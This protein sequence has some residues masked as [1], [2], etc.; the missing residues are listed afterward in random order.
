MYPKWR[1]DLGEKKQELA[2][3]GYSLFVTLDEKVPRS[4][5]LRKRPGLWNWDLQLL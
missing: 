2:N 3:A 4:V 1:L 5:E